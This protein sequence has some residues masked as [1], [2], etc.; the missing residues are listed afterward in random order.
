[1]VYLNELRV[2]RLVC[3]VLLDP[4]QIIECSSLPELFN[5]R[6]EVPDTDLILVDPSSQSHDNVND[7]SQLLTSCLLSV[8]GRE[9]GIQDLEV[10]LC[11]QRRCR[12]GVRVVPTDVEVPVLVDVRPSTVTVRDTLSFEV[13]LATRVDT[14]RRVQDNRL[15]VVRV[16]GSV[17]DRA[18][19]TGSQIFESVNPLSFS[20]YFTLKTSHLS[21][22]SLEPQRLEESRDGGHR[23]R[24]PDLDGVDV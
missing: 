7:F 23:D 20:L 10:V 14:E 17:R 9:E 4:V 6:V 22:R 3:E 24:L 8:K 5:I 2:V 19:H 11:G 13:D 12:V 15:T 1:M 21:D 18:L 16:K